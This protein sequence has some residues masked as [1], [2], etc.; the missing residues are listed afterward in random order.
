MRTEDGHFINKCL[1]GEIEAFGFLVDKYREKRITRHGLNLSTI[2]V[3]ICC[4]K[5]LSTI[6]T[7][8]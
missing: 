2:L 6:F 3:V 4:I 7:M 1:N 8:T 5:A